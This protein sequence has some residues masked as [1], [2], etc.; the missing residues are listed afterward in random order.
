MSKRKFKEIICDKCGWTFKLIAFKKHRDVCNGTG[1]LSDTRKIVANKFKK[2]DDGTYE[3]PH[4]KKGFK[5]L[6]IISHIRLTHN[7]IDSPRFG[8]TGHIP[9]NKGLKSNDNP[10]LANKLRAGGLGLKRKIEN[11]FKPTFSRP[12]FWTIERRKQKSLEKKRLYAEHP[13]KHPNRKVAGNRNKMTYPEKVCHD[14]L[15]LNK[16]SFETQKYIDGKYVD[17]LIG[18][19][20]IEIDGER[21]HP[22]GNENDR[23]RD[24]RLNELGF[25]IF[26]IR[27]KENI[28]ERLK[29]IFSDRC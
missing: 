2:L 17:F 29:D 20:V 24:V 14:W 4:C 16:I 7:G 11:G 27:S 28:E 10:E 25:N 9:W 5:A 23:L 1:R 13:E 12:E 6:G 8:K 19:I 22:I 21:W 3:C 26:R 15:C 18:N